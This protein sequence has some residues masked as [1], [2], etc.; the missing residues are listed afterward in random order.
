MEPRIGRSLQAGFQAAN[1]SWPGIGL[2][3]ATGLLI[4]V[5]TMGALAVTNPPPQLFWESATPIDRAPG[6]GVPL[7]VPPPEQPAGA[8]DTGA[9]AETSSTPTTEGS[10]ASSAPASPGT[11]SDTMEAKTPAPVADQAPTPPAA[12]EPAPAP[13]AVR[14]QDQA[15]VQDWLRRSWPLLL[16]F[17]IIATLA[18]V[19]LSGGQ[20]G[21]VV[22]QVTAAPA[23][24]AEFWNAANRAFVRLLG[25]LA[26]AAAVVA[27]LM[28]VSAALQLLPDALSLVL[29]LALVIAVVW[30]MVRL[31]FWFIMIVAEGRGPIAALGASF[32]AT[33]RR[34]W[35]LVGIG[36]LTGLISYAVMLLERL[37]LWL[38][39]RIGG[40]F[41]MSLSLL[42][43][44]A[45][46]VASLYVAFAALGALVRFYEDARA[47][48]GSAASA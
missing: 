42:A 14:A 26:L 21:Y 9:T 22:K 15:V 47:S 38:A 35:R 7:A 2:F 6:G 45:G 30:L 40:P 41:G 46:T 31:S 17:V 23:P 8:S 37:I 34:W 5:V 33:R 10:D 39:A 48:A 44:L 18:S 19:W 28:A 13:G 24:I 25:G 12:V 29:L 20:I 36:A 11:I 3:A 43:N 27:A 32:R 1:R 16:L 4:A